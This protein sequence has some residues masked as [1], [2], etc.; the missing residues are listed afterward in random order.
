M[1]PRGLSDL[2]QYTNRDPALV[3]GYWPDSQRLDT[4][5]TNTSASSGTGHVTSSGTSSS[6]SLS[7]SLRPVFKAITA[8]KAITGH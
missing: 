6:T 3:V 1:A 4:N 2:C 7:T 8:I 5:S